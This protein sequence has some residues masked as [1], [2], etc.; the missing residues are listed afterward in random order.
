VGFRLPYE[1]TEAMIQCFGKCFH[2]K[3]KVEAFLRSA[4][5]SPELARK[6][7]DEYKYVWARKTLADVANFDDG[8]QATRRVLTE[9]C[10]L[11]DV[12]DPDAPD[13][14][15]ALEAL[16]NLKELAVRHDLYV[17]GQKAA[18]GAR[19][20]LAEQNLRVLSER[21]NKLEGLRKKFAEDVV[22]PN[23]QNA[24]YSLEG[25]LQELFSLFEIDYKKSY[26]TGVEQID[27]HVW[28][29]GFDYLVEARWRQDQPGVQEI[30]GFK[31]KVDLKLESTRGI[32]VAVQG[33]R[34]QVVG[35]F[36]GRG[37]NIIFWDGADLIQVLEGRVDLR[38]GM[39]FKIEKAAQE[40]RTYVPLR[41]FGA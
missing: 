37:C 3:D 26:K 25:L 4:G 24:G 7:R 35:K 10:K 14:A 2:Y 31:T 32:F 22:N 20:A 18:E 5:V 36:L 23:R 29:E 21:A 12:P 38:E 8:Y 15:T 19:Q 30:G 1:I 17:E 40:G 11:R 41:E 27:G 16:R 34:E 39:R 28:F 6:Y 33:F 9:L 13:R